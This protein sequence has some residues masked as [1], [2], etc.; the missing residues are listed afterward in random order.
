M[1]GDPVRNEKGWEREK[2]GKHF[3]VQGG[4]AFK[5]DDFQ[6]EGVLLVRIGNMEGERIKTD[7]D[8]V[9]LPEPYLLDYSDYKLDPGD[10]LVALTGATTGKVAR[11]FEEDPPALL[12]QRVG[13]FVPKDHSKLTLDYLHQVMRTEHAQAYIWQH[14]RGF[15]QPN[16]APRQIEEYEVPVPPLELQKKFEAICTEVFGLSEKCAH[17]HVKVDRLFT[18]LLHHAFTGELTKRWE[19]EKEKHL[20]NARG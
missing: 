15:G 11:Y 3:R 17:S 8:S 13:R 2:L 12:N 4:F 18:V 5:S 1:F 9:Y 10:L 6:E 20:E 19:E 14:A 7:T 16:I